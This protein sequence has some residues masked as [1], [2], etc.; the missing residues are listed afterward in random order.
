[1]RNTIS[2]V[3]YRAKDLESGDVAQLKLHGKSMWVQLT[4]DAAERIENYDVVITYRSTLNQDATII[5][6]CWNLIRV[7]LEK[8][9]E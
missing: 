2:T 9:T 7:Q 8:V 3:N 6:S 1:M 5:M 4:A